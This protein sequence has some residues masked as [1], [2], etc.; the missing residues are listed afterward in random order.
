[1]EVPANYKNAA[2]CNLAGGILNILGGASLLLA[3]MCFGI[4]FA[5]GVFAGGYQAWIGWQMFQGTPVPSGKTAAIAG[6]VGSL[7]GWNPLAFL[8]S[9]GGFYLVGQ[10]DVKGFLEQH[11]AA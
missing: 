3:T 10:E 7:F 4:W 2:L 9:A 6:L 1:M 5:I 11:G 8:A